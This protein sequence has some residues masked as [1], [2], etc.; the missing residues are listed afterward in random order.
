MEAVKNG[1]YIDKATGKKYYYK[2][3]KKIKNQQKKINN[4]WYYFNSVGAMKINGFQ[5][6]TNSKG[7]KKK[8]YYGSN[9]ARV[10]GKKTINGDTCYF[11]QTSGNLVGRINELTYINQNKG[12]RQGGKWTHTNFPNT[13]TWNGRRFG[14]GACGVTSCA[15][16]I[17]ALTN[18]LVLPTKF[19]SIKY[20]FNGIGSNWNVGVLTAKA[21]GLNAK[22]RSLT[23]DEMKNQLLAGRYILC[24]V[25]HSIYGATGGGHFILIHGYKDDKFAVAD[26]NNLTQTY[27]MSNPHKLQSFES[28]NSHLGNGINKSYTVIWK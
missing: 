15:M 23:K 17:T 25:T 8:C 24:W 12:V 3:G 6:L 10:H 11:S 14:T 7:V 1:F 4:K 2:D 9:G 21:Y 27:V 16:A 22:V 18:K 20:G 26:P 13:K 19:N 28:F 5:T